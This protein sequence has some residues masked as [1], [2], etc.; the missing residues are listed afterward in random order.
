MKRILSVL[1]SVL[2]LMSSFAVSFTAHAEQFYNWT[3]N[4]NTS[5]T[6]CYITGYTGNTNIAHVLLPSYLGGMA[7][8]DVAMSMTKFPELETLVFYDDTIMAV[9]PNCSG[10]SNLDKVSIIDHNNTDRV[11]SENKLPDSIKNVTYNAFTGTSIREIEMPCVETIGRAFSDGAF[12]NCDK[13]N[14]VVISK[15]ARIFADSFARIDSECDIEYNGP[16]SEWTG[17]TVRYSPK[18][19]ANCNDG[20]FGWCGDSWDGTGYAFERS[21]LYWKLTKEGEL[22]VDSIYGSEY[23]EKQTV[24]TH[25]WNAF[26]VTSLN[27]KNVY[28]TGKETFRY[29][30]IPTLELPST[31]NTIGDYSFANCGS[32]TEVHIPKSVKTIGNYAFAYCGKLKDIYYDGTFDEWNSV[33]KKQGWNSGIPSDVRIHCKSTVNFDVNGHGK[34]PA[35]QTGLVSYTDKVAEPAAPSEHQYEFLGWY[36][37]NDCVEKWDFDKDIVTGDMTLY[38][39]WKRVL[40]NVNVTATEGGNPTADKTEAYE[41]TLIHLNPNELEG[42]VFKEWQIVSGDANIEHNSFNMPAEDVTV[43]AVYEQVKNG[44]NVVST[45][46]GSAFADKETAAN[47]E[48][49]N[50]TATPD[51][52]WKFKEWETVMGGVSVTGNENATFVMSNQPNVVV[53]AVFERITY[54]LTI[55]TNGNGTVDTGYNTNEIPEGWDVSLNAYPEDGYRLKNISFMTEGVNFRYPYV[56]SMPRYAT[57]VYAEFEPIP[58]SKV[59]TNSTGNGTIQADREYAESGENVHITVTPAEGNRLKGINVTS[60]NAELWIEEGGYGFTMPDD[61]VVIA[62]EFEEI[63][64]IHTLSGEGVVF[65][66]DGI[67]K[68]A[69]A[70]EGSNVTVSID[71]TQIPDGYY[72]TKSYL[73]NDVE[74]SVED[75][76]DGTFVMPRHDVTVTPVFAERED[77]EIDLTGE[78]AVVL[79]EEDLAGLLT[80]SE[81]V[82]YDDRQDMNYFDFNNDGTPDVWLDCDKNTV[83]RAEGADDLTD[84]SYTIPVDYLIPPRFKTLKF[85]FAFEPAPTVETYEVKTIA[86]E[87]GSVSEGALYEKGATAT[88]T[89]TPA[90]GYEFDGWYENGEKVSSDLSY[91]FEVTRYTQL[92]AK[93]SEKIVAYSIT[94]SSGKYTYNTGVKKITVTVYDRNKKPLSGRKVTVIMNSK[95]S[96]LTTGADGKV[97]YSLSTAIKPKTYTVSVSCEGVK[98]SSKVVINKAKPKLS[99]SAKSYKK[100]AKTKKYTVKLKDNNGKAVKKAMITLKINGKTYKALTNAKGVA[101]F[102]FKNLMKKGKYT[103]AVK[104][105]GN[106]FFTSISKK[107]IINVK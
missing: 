70:E 72:F 94:V 3:V 55:H 38:A 92:V 80:E 23:L 102:S 25:R 13:L 33:E 89:A 5:R 34:A 90:E 22:T 77:G 79:P 11:I 10:C 81:F 49:V 48:T 41:N 17:E 78:D 95:T 83:Q 18:L 91:S 46:G 82:G 88:V 35:S 56:F 21:N 96:T 27:L 76:S 31:V 53:R 68:I 73:A 36:K 104:F 12:E 61:E 43:K 97:K 71:D 19:K 52:G 58:V 6:Q 2:L 98:G 85:I 69:E 86:E 47:G 74:I 32:L 87:G 75:T 39:K 15:P 30:S 93:F 103:A 8:I 45:N 16:L 7:V 57:D 63:P 1:L 64:P 37:E 29:V 99:A 54:K 67:N 106:S 44:I 40:F 50:L 42:W 24:K 28:N 84:K 65:F 20:W 100:T 101:T 60:G 26:Q 66:D 4:V 107:V 105:A 9:T 14:K 62:A 51:A 59:N